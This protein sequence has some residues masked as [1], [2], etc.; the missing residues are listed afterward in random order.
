MNWQEHLREALRSPAALGD[1]LGRPV[2]DVSYPLLIPR[3]LAE[4]ILCTGDGSPLW[5]QFVPISEE[6][7]GAGQEDPI[8]DHRHAAGGGLIHRYGNR[9]LF[10]STSRCPVLCRYCFRKNEL[11]SPDEMFASDPN[12][13]VDYLR[14]HPQIEEIICSGGDPFILSNQRLE[15]S[16]EIFAGIPSL[17]YLRFHTRTP[18]V[19]PSRF[20]DE[21]LLRLLSMAS[22]QFE[23]VT[24]VVHINHADELDPTVEGAIR[25]LVDLPLHMTSQSVLL[26]GVND[27]S[28]ALKKLFVKLASLGVKP[29]YLHH[30]DKVRGGM[31]FMISRQEGREIY[32]RLR[33]EA[34]A[35]VIPHYVVESPEGGGK[36]LAG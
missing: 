19:L 6:E 32:A 21:G 26:R 31:H 22:E 11:A 14:R 9:A 29:Y 13:T 20:E 15:N 3:P 25:K 17:K 5:R 18:V 27:S 2:A 36:V 30:P 1:F 24:V 10:L 12:K 23:L 35:Q 7:E 4:R 16:L 34:V 33:S 8:G 28:A